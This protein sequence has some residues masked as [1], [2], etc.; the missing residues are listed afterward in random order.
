MRCRSIGGLLCI[1][2]VCLRGLCVN[3][4]CAVSAAGEIWPDF[5]HILH[6]LLSSPHWF[7]SATNLLKDSEMNAPVWQ[8]T[9][10]SSSTTS[11]H[12]ILSLHNIVFSCGIA[13]PAAVDPHWLD[14]S[15]P[16]FLVV[17]KAEGKSVFKYVPVDW[18]RCL[19]LTIISL[20]KV[21]K[22]V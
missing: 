15:S 3:H 19:T 13:F 9:S 8:P 6:Y 18:S 4:L 12:L 22:I 1:S 2:A 20:E 21:G 7:P 10:A 5:Q 14:L 11:Q 17:I 16:W